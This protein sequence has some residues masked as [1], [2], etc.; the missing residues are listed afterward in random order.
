MFPVDPLQT[1]RRE[2]QLFMRGC[3]HLLA[4]ICFPGSKPLTEHERCL[5]ERYGKEFIKVV[6]ALTKK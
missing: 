4:A 5:I 2:A 3:E 6:L 1:V